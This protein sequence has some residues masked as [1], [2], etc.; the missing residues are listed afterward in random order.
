MSYSMDIWNILRLASVIEKEERNA[1]N[2]PTVAG[3]FFNR[4]EQ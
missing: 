4:L 1:Q 3:I 2:K